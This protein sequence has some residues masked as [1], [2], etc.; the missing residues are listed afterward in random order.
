MYELQE[1]VF[2]PKGGSRP[3]SAVVEMLFSDDAARVDGRSQRL[4]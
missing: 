1:I 3:V 4:L 2:V